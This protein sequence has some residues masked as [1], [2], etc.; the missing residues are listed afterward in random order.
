[1]LSLTRPEFYVSAVQVSSENNVGKGEID[2]NEQFLLF[3]EGFY[4]FGEFS[5]L[6]IKLKIVACELFQFGIF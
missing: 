4:P 6:F 2:C 5:A 3:P 1:M